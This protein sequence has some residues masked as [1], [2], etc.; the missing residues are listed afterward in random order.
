MLMYNV[1]LVD[2]SNAIVTKW[3][4]VKF[5]SEA[6]GPSGSYQYQI[7]CTPAAEQEQNEEER[8]DKL[9]VPVPEVDMAH[10]KSDHQDADEEKDE[11]EKDENFSNAR[12]QLSWT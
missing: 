8:S 9:I 2:S 4:K 6:V 7:G 3:V 11:S 10:A 12:W 5:P 1:I